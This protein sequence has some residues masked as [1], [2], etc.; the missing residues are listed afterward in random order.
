MFEEF[1]TAVAAVRIGPFKIIEKIG[2]AAYRLQLPDTMKIHDVFH[3]S[4][5]DPHVENKFASRTTPPPPPVIIDGETEFEVE[6][7]LDS[8]LYRNHGQ[9]LVKWIGYSDSDNTWEPY[10]NLTNASEMIS[11]FHAKYRNKPGPWT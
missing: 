9:Y 6:E 1:V 10:E 11:K 2:K 4:L 5:L 3:V 7:I 8:R